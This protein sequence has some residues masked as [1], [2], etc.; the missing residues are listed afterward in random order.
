VNRTHDG[1]DLFRPY[2]T[3]RL[4]DRLDEG[5]WGARAPWLPYVYGWKDFFVLESGGRVRACAGLWDRGRDQRDHLRHRST[6]EERTISHAA[7]MDWGFEP[8]AESAMLELLDF[9]VG[10]AHALGRTYLLAPLE[11]LRELAKR[12]EIFEPVPERRYL[13]WPLTDPAVTRPYTDLAY[14]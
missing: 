12:A 2:T 1:L 11:P 6:G 4:S 5:Y 7:L 10:R 14:W 3:E 8:G 9:L 13:R